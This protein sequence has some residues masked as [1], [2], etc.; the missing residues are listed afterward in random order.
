MDICT[1]VTRGIETGEVIGLSAA[2]TI[3]DKTYDEY[4]RHS[5]YSSDEKLAILSFR[6]KVLAD[7]NEKIKEVQ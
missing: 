4:F 6:T 2:L 1:A 5:S 7:I 3:V